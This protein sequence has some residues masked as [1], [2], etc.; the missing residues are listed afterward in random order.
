MASVLSIVFSVIGAIVLNAAL[1]VWTALV[2]PRPVERARQRIESRPI[3]C[4][5]TG[6]IVIAAAAGLTALFYL[7]RGPILIATEKLLQY[8][9]DIMHVTRFY[10]DTWTFA[11]G[12]L[13]FLLTPAMACWAIGLSAFAQLFAIRARPLMRDDRPL[14]GVAWGALCTTASGFVPI[15]GWFLFVPL[16]GLISVGAGLQALISRSEPPKS[17]PRP[18]VERADPV[19]AAK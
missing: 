14:L 9:S 17:K 16:V 15:V 4:L 10:N 18:D 12:L 13:W 6:L 7:V 5:F 11:N 3:N 1:L 2:L 19:V 8:L